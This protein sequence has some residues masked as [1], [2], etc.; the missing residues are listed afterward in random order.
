[1]NKL[2]W[3][4][5]RVCRADLGLRARAAARSSVLNSG[6]LPTTLLPNPHSQLALLARL[7]SRFRL[8]RP[9]R[10]SAE[11]PSERGWPRNYPSQLIRNTE[12]RQRWQRLAFRVGQRRS[13]V[14]TPIAR[15]QSVWTRRLWY[16]TYS[17]SIT[18]PST[19]RKSESGRV[20]PSTPRTWQLIAELRMAPRFPI[21]GEAGR[22]LW[23]MAPDA[24]G[25]WPRMLSD[26]GWPRSPLLTAYVTQ[27]SRCRSSG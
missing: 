8:G 5:E 22:P 11:F 15:G 4:E 21:V 23:W 2:V 19:R 26:V 20:G 1:M 25:G 7:A 6:R 17:G 12:C 16:S 13:R 18:W 24:P 27:V 14:S 3:R 9:F 10:R